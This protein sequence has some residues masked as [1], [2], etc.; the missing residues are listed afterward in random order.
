MEEFIRNS[1]EFK[2]FGF[3]ILTLSFLGTFSFS[4]FQAWSLYR[5]GKNI[6]D[7]EKGESVSIVQ[8][9]YWSAYF[10][11]IIPFG[12]SIGSVALVLNG[13]L[14]FLCLYILSG[15]WKF[16]DSEWYEWPITATFIAIIMLMIIADEI[17]EKEMIFS[18]ALFGILLFGLFQIY[19]IWKNKDGGKVDLRVQKV[20]I[21]TSIFWFFYSIFIGNL[22]L[23]IFNPISIGMN[24]MIIFL[25]KKYRSAT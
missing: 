18:V 17:S 15:L 5:Q 22:S 25:C 11:A 6:W 4:C 10:F 8:F 3:N 23:M 7:S 21:V 24:V 12:F 16:K 13:L 19:E 9:G 2:N 14:G 1:V 20:F